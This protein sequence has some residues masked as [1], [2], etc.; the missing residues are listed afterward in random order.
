M[1]R[2]ILSGAPHNTQWKELNSVDDICLFILGILTACHCLPLVLSLFL[3]VILWRVSAKVWDNYRCQ[4]NSVISRS[5]FCM[6]RIPRWALPNS[7]LLTTS[8]L[9]KNSTMHNQPPI[10]TYLPPTNQVKQTKTKK[11]FHIYSPPRPRN[12]NTLFIQ[13]YTVR[14]ATSQTTLWGG[15]PGRD[16][17][18]GRAIYKIG[19][20]CSFV[21]ISTLQ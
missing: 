4:S 16:S 10:C 18:L 19:W 2:C 21:D 9:L 15:P 3:C 12:F 8:Y 7:K 20:H 17:N 14:S 11:C 13:Y 1:Q 6:D 5:T